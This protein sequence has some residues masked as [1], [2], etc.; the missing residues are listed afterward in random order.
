[1]SSSARL[2]K[3]QKGESAPEERGAAFSPQQNVFIACLALVVATL[4]FY[5]PVA[6]CGFVYSDDIAYV[7]GN[8]QVQAGLTWNTVVWAFSE[9]H[10]G[11]YHPLTYLSHALDCQLFGLNAAGHHYVSLLLHTASAVLLFLILLEATGAGWPSLVVAALFALHPEN[12][13]SVAWASERKNVLSMFF[14]LLA[15]WAYGRYVKR[16]G[17]GRYVAVVLLFAAGLLAKTQI[18]TLPCVLLLWD[19]WPLGRMFSAP[20]SAEGASAPRSFGY[21]VK[22]KIPLFLLAAASS[23]I[24]VIAQRQESAL[25]TLGEYSFSA[26]MGNAIVSYARYLGHTFWPVR[27]A[28][29][30]PHTG[31]PPMGQ[32][33]AA[34][35]LLALVTA[36]VIWQRER[37]YLMVG[38]FWFL[39][40]LVPVIGIVQTGEQAMADRYAYLPMIG[41]FLMLVWPIAAAVEAKRIAKAWA[42]V[43]A[44][45]VLVTL[46]VLTYRQLAHWHDGETLWRYTISVTDRNYLAH[47]NLAMV[48]DGEG[49]PDEAIGEFLVSEQ[50]HQYPPDQLL[51]IGLYEQRNGHFKGAIEQYQKV[52]GSAADAKLRAAAWSQTGSAYAQMGDFEQAKKSYENGLQANPN[53]APSLVGSAM[54]AARD[55]NFSEAVIRLSQAMKVEPTDVGYL[56]L[57]DALRHAGRFQE[58]QPDEDLAGKISPN[59]DQARKNATDTQLFFGYKAK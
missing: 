35:M 3:Q 24:T 4:A 16:G 11:F 41:L 43:P 40:T 39:G 17:T 44:V 13:E 30:Y 58:A 14:F 8:P 51:K 25:R 7:T 56:L 26:R 50:Y 59:L 12:V 10:T 53:D 29:I 18:I 42:A 22:E 33:A 46:G 45:V 55:G 49:R 6:H 2:R 38:W 21:L 9:V 54:L 23:V 27:L 52:S 31:V 47:D 57:A 1:M 32:I 36:V 5:N 19:Y 28:P 15:L 48:L 34:A 37:R 20:S